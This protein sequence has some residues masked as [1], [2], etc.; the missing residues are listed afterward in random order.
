MCKL[1]GG[2]RAAGDLTVT[3]YE[4]DEALV[5]LPRPPK[6]LERVCK[7]RAK[8]GTAVFGLCYGCWD[9]QARHWW[10][11]EPWGGAVPQSWPSGSPKAT[12]GTMAASVRLPHLGAPGQPGVS[13]TSGSTSTTC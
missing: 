13:R 3:A 6:D 12:K 4:L 11:D 7:G 9:E 8:A 10:S 5:V 1:R 2:A